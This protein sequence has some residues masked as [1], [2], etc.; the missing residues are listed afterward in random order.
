MNRMDV[1]EP[2]SDSADPVDVLEQE[3]PATNEPQQRDPFGGDLPDE[4]DPADVLEQRYE[5]PTGDDERMS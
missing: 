5:V 2:W 4:A 1:S 3:I